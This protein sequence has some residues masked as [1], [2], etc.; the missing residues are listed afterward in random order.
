MLL[1]F[2]TPIYEIKISEKNLLIAKNSFLKIFINQLTLK[3][4][5]ILI[6]ANK[7]DTDSQVHSDSEDNISPD[8]MAINKYLKEYIFIYD[9]FKKNN[10]CDQ[11]IQR[12]HQKNQ[13]F[14]RNFSQ[15][16][17]IDSIN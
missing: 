9:L 12:F 15:N 5:L 14:K 7:T 3:K 17:V 11:K 8:S 10:D 6:K 2:F 16:F 1:S 13:G 4:S